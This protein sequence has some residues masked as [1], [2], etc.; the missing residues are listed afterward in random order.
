MHTYQLR[1]LSW[2]SPVYVIHLFH[3]QIPVHCQ[4]YADL[5]NLYEPLT[6]TKKN[7]EFSYIL[8]ISYNAKLYL[9]CRSTCIFYLKDIKQWKTVFLTMLHFF[10]CKKKTKDCQY[11]SRSLFVSKCQYFVSYKPQTLNL[12]SALSININVTSL[13]KSFFFLNKY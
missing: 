4:H 7:S 12:Y 10:L 2:F 6:Y 1:E 11:C 8:H 13:P 3:L 5:P 9:I